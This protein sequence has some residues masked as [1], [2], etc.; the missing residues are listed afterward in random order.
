MQKYV[1]TDSCFWI[2][3][4][5]DTDQHHRDSM[6][7]SEVVEDSILILP[8]PCLYETVNTRLTRQKERLALFEQLIN[9]SNVRVI[10]DSL[11][12]EVALDKVFSRNRKFD[13]YSPSLVDA[14]LREMIL[15]IN[16]KMVYFIS[17]NE[18]DFVDVCVKRNIEFIR[19]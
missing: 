12:R 16:I 15:D 8:Y 9:K 4:I 17:F 13:D 5:D 1:L 7:I 14:V 10:S 11:Y 2:G 6:I 18:R 19:A 3:L